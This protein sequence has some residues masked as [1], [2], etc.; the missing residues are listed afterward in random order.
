M[1]ELKTSN[2]VGKRGKKRYG[3]LI[4]FF[5]VLKCIDCIWMVSTTLSTYFLSFIDLR[6]HSE[7]EQF[8]YLNLNWLKKSDYHYN[9][10][11][12]H[13][14][15]AVMSQIDHCTLVKLPSHFEQY[16]CTSSWPTTVNVTIALHSPTYEKQITLQ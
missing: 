8:C 1:H 6:Y 5:L 13:F 4:I 2:F 7:I 12:V 15:P 9:S 11:Y 3:C 14:K 16:Y 10:T